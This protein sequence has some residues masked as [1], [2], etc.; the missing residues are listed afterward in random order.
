MQ[1]IFWYDWVLAILL[2]LIIWLW[3]RYFIQKHAEQPLIQQYFRKGL[4]IKIL[5]SIAFACYHAYIYGGGDTFGYFNM[6]KDIV[7]HSNG[8]FG[9]LLNIVFQPVEWNYD[10]LNSIG[11]GPDDLYIRSE[12]NFFQVRLATLL[13]LVTCKSYL[14]TGIMFSV[15]SYWGIWKAFV[16]FDKIYAGQQKRLAIAFLY[17]PTVVF[18]GS[19]LGKDSLALGAICAFI[20]AIVSVFITK[21]KI[22]KH[23]LL[24]LL[25]G[26]VLLIVKS[27]IILALI[28]ALL[29]SLALLYIK[30][31]KRTL[32]KIM[33]TPIVLLMLYV[34]GFFFVGYVNEHFEDF[35]AE[36]LADRIVTSNLNLQ[37]DAGSAFDLGIRPENVSGLRD[38]AG[39]FPKAVV[40]SCFRP[41]I[42]EA[43]NPAMLLSALE[44]LF[45]LMLSIVLLIKGRIFKTIQITLSDP[46]LIC[47]LLYG[48]VFLGLV[49]L[50]TSNFGTL[51][52]YKLPC[53]PFILILL[54]I[55][56]NRLSKNKYHESLD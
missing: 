36:N 32:S 29:I 49:G 47:F 23:A 1:Y 3:T 54:F 10:Y 50:S 4:L 28:P 34:A 44:G 52:R 48:F 43:K 46:L 5:A 31:R 38:L 22:W 56:Y 40:A 21:E 6:A 7:Q 19:G 53:M 11:T 42:W 17:F 26:G 18:W 27:Y 45:L 35:S 2:I 51:V 12:S 9:R 37:A 24:A 39:F 41:W 16:V 33:L 20:A 30:N 13:L 25:M 8:H 15:L 14:T 55:T